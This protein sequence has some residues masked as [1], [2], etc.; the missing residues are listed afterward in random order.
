MHPFLQLF[1]LVKHSTC[2]GRSFRPIIRSSRPHIQQHS[3]AK[4]LLLPA[5]SGNEIEPFPL[6]AGSSSCLTYARCCMCSLGLLMMGRKD[7]P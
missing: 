4:Q 7:R 6:T 5:V 2:Y 1:I 3:Y